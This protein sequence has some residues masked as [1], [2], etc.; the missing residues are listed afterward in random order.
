MNTVAKGAAKAGGAV[1][2]LGTLKLRI[3]IGLS[4]LLVVLFTVMVIGFFQVMMD[5]TSSDNSEGN[6]TFVAGGTQNISAKIENLRPVYEQYAEEFGVSDHVNVLMALSMQ[7]SGGRVDD[8]MQSSESLG[9]PPNTID[10]PERSIEQGV[11]Y[12]SKVLED[13][14]GDVK[15]ALQSYNFGGGFIDYANAN[16]D[17]EYSKDLA[18]EFSRQQY[19]KVKSTGNYSC[20]RPESAE[21]GACYGDIGYVDAVMKYVTNTA[22][23]QITGDV[24]E[25]VQVGEKWIGNSNYVFGGGRTRSDQQAGRFDCSSFVFWAYEQVGVELGNLG[26]VNTDS[27]KTKGQRVDYSN[28]QPGD[29]VFFDTYKLDGHV[30]IYAGDGKFIGSQGSTG[31]A[32]E[33]MEDGYWGDNFNGRVKRISS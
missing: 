10:D 19:Q 30:G 13:A 22:T 7:E 12:F 32:I 28:A 18:I 6:G 8:I 14:N 16:N 15:L 25:V 20:I 27:L 17:G 3:I 2:K 23:T 4:A 9:L 24:A 5:T 21:T 1:L 33:S 11:R 29:L 26:S 31:V